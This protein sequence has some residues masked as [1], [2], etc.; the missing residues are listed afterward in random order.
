MYFDK[1]QTWFPATVLG[2][3]DTCNFT[4]HTIKQY[5]TK[6]VSNHLLRN[7]ENQQKTFSHTQKIRSKKQPSV[8]IIH[9]QQIH[10]QSYAPNLAIIKK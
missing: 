2:L 4:D 9:N 1:I 6:Q 3:N 7:N 5:Q 8:M 10:C